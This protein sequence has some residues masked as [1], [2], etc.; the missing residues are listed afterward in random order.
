MVGKSIA[1]FIKRQSK[2]SH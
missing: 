1:A 2:S